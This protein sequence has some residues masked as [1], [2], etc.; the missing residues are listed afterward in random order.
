MENKKVTFSFYGISLIVEAPA[1][2]ARQL[3][4]DFS[5]FM[6]PSLPEAPLLSIIRIVAH[7]NSPVGGF[8]PPLTASMSLADGVVYDRDNIR[9]VDYNGKAVVRYDYHA[10]SGELYSGDPS[11]LHE[12]LY[13]LIH[14]RVGELLDRRGFH[15]VHALGIAVAG[16]GILCLLPQGGGKTTLFLELMKNPATMILSDDTPLIDRGGM[17]FPFPVRVG[18]AEEKVPSHIPS[19]AV[20]IFHRRNHGSKALIDISFFSE[21]ISNPTNPNGRACGSLPPFYPPEQG[22]HVKC[23]L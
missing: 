5:Y 7:G 10:E 12:L 3:Q 22:L 2:T 4:L 11:L 1:E 8:I 21:K 19:A 9:Y 23:S 18:V 17:L 16:R 6:V 13:L 20:T 14:S 15:R